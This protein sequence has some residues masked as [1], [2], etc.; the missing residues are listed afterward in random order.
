MTR[1][2]RVALAMGVGLL[3]LGATVLAWRT[4]ALRPPSVSEPAFDAATRVESSVAA[5]PA[6][7][8]EAPAGEASKAA[9]A[10]PADP[11][12]DATGAPPR[13]IVRARVEAFLAA[14]FADRA[15][16]SGDVESLVDAAIDLHDSNHELARLQNDLEGADRRDAALARARRAAETWRAILEIEPFDVPQ[17]R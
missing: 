10:A 15:L 16:R 4:T 17:V 6:R 7:P 11:A 2:V 5:T 1:A 14:R 9:P 13:E 3:A 8:T 12:W